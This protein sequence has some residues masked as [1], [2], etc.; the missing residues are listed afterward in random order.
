MARP[1]SGTYQLTRDGD[2]LEAVF[3]S[4]DLIREGNSGGRAGVGVRMGLSGIANQ[5]MLASIKEPKKAEFFKEAYHEVYDG[6]RTLEAHAALQ[7]K[8]KP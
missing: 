2:G 4:S 5:Y 6:R 3:N 1:A 7:K 8:L